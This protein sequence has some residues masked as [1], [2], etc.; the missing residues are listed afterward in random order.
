MI[1]LHQ[2]RRRFDSQAR[3]LGCCP[4][5][6]PSG[7][8]TYRLWVREQG[9]RLV[10]TLEGE[11]EEFEPLDRLELRVLGVEAPERGVLAGPA[12]DDLVAFGKA[13]ERL[14]QILDR[15]HGEV[16]CPPCGGSGR[17]QECQGQG[18][19]FV[20]IYSADGR[21]IDEEK[22]ECWECDGWSTCRVC[23]PTESKTTA[24]EAA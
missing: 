24:A 14:R 21:V 12:A 15:I 22:I 1:D 10:F 19:T 5:G 7:E 18:E 13:A 6:E 23:S 8:P 3:A 9:L 2:V 17:C 20:H 4:D 11:D 16:A